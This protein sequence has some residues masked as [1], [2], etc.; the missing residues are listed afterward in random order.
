MT[1][2]PGPTVNHKAGSEKRDDGYR[3]VP[4]KAWPHWVW[5]CKRHGLAKDG[6]HYRFETSSKTRIWFHKNIVD[7]LFKESA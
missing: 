1:G 4:K 5:I 6:F 2:F 7:R 3:V